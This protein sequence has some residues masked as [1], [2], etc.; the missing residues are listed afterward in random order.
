MSTLGTASLLL[1]GFDVQWGKD[2][3]HA[4]VAPLQIVETPAA[5][6]VA[7]PVEVFVAESDHDRIID[8]EPG[9]A[10]SVEGCSVSEHLMIKNDRIVLD[11]R[12]LFETGKSRVRW[13]G[14]AMIGEIA[15]TWHRHP[16]WRRVTIEG[17]T[18]VRGSDAL[19]QKLSE[20]RAESAR[21]ELVRRGFAAAAIDVVGYGRSR[22]RDPGTDD[23][24]LQRNRRVEFV[25][26]REVT[27]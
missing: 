7:P 6:I 18:D 19:N 1:V 3:N 2:R 8:R 26:D 9:C 24:A 17:H 15:D 23:A 5:A 10:E 20:R 16:D 11:E 27:Q 22:P 4:R 25:I 14:R 12:V 13:T 21:A